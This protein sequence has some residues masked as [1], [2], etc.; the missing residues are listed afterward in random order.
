[1]RS[2]QSSDSRTALEHAG[3][4]V[5]WELMR[6]AYFTS[7]RNTRK[8]AECQALADRWCTTRDRLWQEA[9]G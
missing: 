1:M 5:H 6:V 9:Q 8:A 7:L 4:A 3:W 2:T